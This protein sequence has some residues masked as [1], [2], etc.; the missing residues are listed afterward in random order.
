MPEVE[1]FH[2]PSCGAPLAFEE[3]AVTIS[4]SFCHNQVILPESLR[5]ITKKP[6]TVPGIDTVDLG[7]IFL[8]LA[9]DR[10][11]NAIK[12]T[13][14]ATGLG[15]K[16]SKD[17]VEALERGE[18]INITQMTMEV[19]PASK[20]KP[21]SGFCGCLIVLGIL[22]SILLPFAFVLAEENTFVKKLISQ[23][24]PAGFASIDLTLDG[25]EGTGPGQ[26]DSP[27]AIAAD[28]DGNIFVADYQ[29]GRI[30]SFDSQGN[31][32]WVVNLGRKTIIQSMDIANGDVLLVATGGDIRRFDRATG[33]ELGVFQ[34]QGS[35]YYYEDIAIAPDGRIVT[36][37]RGQNLVVF[38]PDLEILFEVKEAVSSITD[39]SELSSNVAVDPTGSIYILGSF[40]SKVL[41]YSPEGRYINQFGG[42]T[43]EPANGK[44]RAVGDIAVDMNGRVYVSD[45]SG[46]QVFDPEGQYI[47]RFKVNGVAHGMNFDLQNR[48]YIASNKP[49]ILRMDLRK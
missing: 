24:N 37:S 48:M 4:C 7:D 49:Q 23:V 45:I 2:C 42:S 25:G 17:I 14:E 29:T 18:D 40:N 43:T 6:E 47:D 28:R 21:V 1:K 20:A 22:L 32:R 27:R 5:R 30:Q 46:I 13:R 3:N 35:D 10:K 16:E 38:S 36:I 44:F 31:F 8:M 19:K 41:K 34:S 15:L 12:R 11:I 9:N 26:F 39:D 33:A